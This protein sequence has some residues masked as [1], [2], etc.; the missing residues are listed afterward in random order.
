M[1]HSLEVWSV[2]VMALLAANLPFF[3]PRLMLVGPRRSPKPLAW[4]LAELL[5][6][7]LLA[8]GAG[9]AIE[10]QIGQ[11]APQNWEFFAAWACLM[12]S[13]AFPGFVWRTLRRSTADA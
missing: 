4:C 6:L 12:L 1:A 13:F 10:V 7:G 3:S 8:L 5:L 11:R 2:I 9:V